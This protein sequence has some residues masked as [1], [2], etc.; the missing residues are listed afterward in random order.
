MEGH[1]GSVVIVSTLP[2]NYY[3]NIV[4]HQST[5]NDFQSDTE[6]RKFMS[7]YL[8]LCTSYLEDFETAE[9]SFKAIAVATILVVAI[10][11]I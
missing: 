9:G 5:L 3:R 1:V 2:W 8:I 6:N 4:D 10:H 7:L 11:W